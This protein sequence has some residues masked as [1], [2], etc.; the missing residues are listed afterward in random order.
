M[1]TLMFV[2]KPTI[3][4]SLATTCTSSMLT[5]FVVAV[6][7]H[8]TLF[9]TG[10]VHG[11]ACAAGATTTRPPTAAAD[12]VARV[13]RRAKNRR[14][15]GSLLGTS[16]RAGAPDDGEGRLPEDHQVKGEGPVLHVTQVQPDRLVPGEIAAT[17][18]LPQPRYAR[19]DQQTAAYVVAV[20]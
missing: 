1:L 9:T 10:A 4:S 15:I 14:D 13:S 18:D 7:S 20:E 3:V 17:A 11:A 12:A 8:S 6:F 19:L 16:V 2:G 5:T